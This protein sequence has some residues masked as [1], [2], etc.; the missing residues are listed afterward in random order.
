MVIAFI[1]IALF[2]FNETLF[3]GAQLS[4]ITNLLFSPALL[5]PL[6]VLLFGGAG[7]LGLFLGALVT[8]PIAS[9]SGGFNLPIR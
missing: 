4:P 3:A 8:S 5:R 6:A 2:E 9:R 1:W 7:V